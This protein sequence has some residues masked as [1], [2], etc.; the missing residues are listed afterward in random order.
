MPDYSKA[1]DEVRV[2]ADLMTW[3]TVHGNLSLALRHPGNVG[4][5]RKVVEVFLE[6]LG[7]GLVENG[8]LSEAELDFI[9]WA[10]EQ[11]RPPA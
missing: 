10:E 1:R 11:R 6:Q 4:P 9:R 8:F 3:L 2:V 5:S 7:R